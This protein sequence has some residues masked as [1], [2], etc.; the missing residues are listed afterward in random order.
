MKRGIALLITLLFIIS[1]TF[2][3]GLGLKYIKQASEATKKESFMIQTSLIV[4]DVMQLLKDTKEIDL[5]V[6][7]KSPEMLSMFLSQAEFIPFESSGIKMI[8]ELNSA[9]GKFNP[10]TL[11]D[12]NGT[13]NAS[14]EEALKIYLSEKSINE[15]YTDMLVDMMSKVKQD[16]S[17]NTDIFNYKPNLFRD[18]IVSYK[19]L[20]EINEFYLQTYREKHINSID[21]GKL[22]Y[23]SKD[24]DY[25]I[26]LNYATPEVWQLLLGCEKLRAQELS[27]GAGSYTKVDELFLSDEEKRQLARFKSDYFQPIIDVKVEIMQHDM[28]AKIYFEYNMKTK[29][30][31]N[32]S[33][34]I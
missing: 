1:I 16:M 14:V 28:S 21:F 29:K 3:I 10:N 26:D 15:S 25:K 31:S 24:R 32:F 12:V 22:F 34:E 4:N 6:K 30:G 11:V 8:L 23:F 27:S 5:I 19:H 9:R 7:E 2:A 17:Y 20:S 18:Y 33:Y 13:L